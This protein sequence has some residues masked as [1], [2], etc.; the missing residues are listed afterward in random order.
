MQ[1][2]WI[3]KDWVKLSNGWERWIGLSFV[4]VIFKDMTLNNLVMMRYSSNNV[5]LVLLVDTLILIG[6]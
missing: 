2:N 6:R 1:F 4:F 5:I 3:S